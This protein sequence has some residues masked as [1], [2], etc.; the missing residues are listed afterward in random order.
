MERRC[1][2]GLAPLLPGCFAMNLDYALVAL[3]RAITGLALVAVAG[4]LGWRFY[5]NL[6]ARRGSRRMR[7]DRRRMRVRVAQDRRK[8]LRRGRDVEREETEKLIR[9][10]RPPRP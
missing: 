4:Y 7:A 3:L 6:R 10:E 8:Q 1:C 9:G 5:K 2:P